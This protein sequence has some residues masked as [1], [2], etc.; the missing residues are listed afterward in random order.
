MPLSAHWLVDEL[1]GSWIGEQLCLR[2]EVQLTASEAQSYGAHVYER[3]RM[4]AVHFVEGKL[5]A[6]AYTLEEVGALRLGVGQLGKLVHNIWD[7]ALEAAIHFSL[8]SFDIRHLAR[9]FRSLAFEH[10]L[11][12][13]FVGVRY[14][15]PDAHCVGVLLNSV[16]K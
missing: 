5:L 11:A 9:A 14:L 13:V 3:A 7:G 1:V 2:I 12:T 8:R 6:S 10:Y 16:E 15:M 4:M